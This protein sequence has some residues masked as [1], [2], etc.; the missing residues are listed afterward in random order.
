MCM[1]EVELPGRPSAGVPSPQFTVMP[2][3]DTVLDTVNV[4]VT[5]WPVVVGLGVGLL[6]FTVGGETGV[7]TLTDPVPW[8]VESL[9]STAVTVIVNVLAEP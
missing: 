7:W 1:P 9:L 5:V 6:T 8:P 4:T 2:V 3:T